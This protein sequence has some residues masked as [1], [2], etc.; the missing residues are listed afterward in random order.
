MADSRYASSLV[1]R[2]QSNNLFLSKQKPVLFQPLSKLIE[3]QVKQGETLQ[4][5]AGT[6]YRDIPRGNELWWVL[7]D[8]Q[9]I[10]IL[11]PLAELETGTTIYVLSQSDLHLLLSE[12]GN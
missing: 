8:F 9:P 6:Y 4:R 5:I 12:S 11:D 7:A 1:F 2:D 10:P 3:H